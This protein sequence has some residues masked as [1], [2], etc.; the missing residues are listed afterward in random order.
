MDEQECIKSD[1]ALS[2]FVRAALR[3]LISADPTFLP[4]KILVK[5]FNATIA[6]GLCAKVQNP[7]GPTARDVCQHLLD[8][9]WAHADQEEKRYLPLIKKRIEQGSLSDAIRR[10]VLKEA[11]RLGLEEAIVKVYSKLIRSL[12]ANEPYF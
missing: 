11:Q 12:A 10:N 8:V 2:C 7:R 9:A 6:N 3:G 1:V 5:D 4:H